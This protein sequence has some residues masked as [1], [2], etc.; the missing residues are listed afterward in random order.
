MLLTKKAQESR[1]VRYASEVLQ[2]ISVWL[3]LVCL[4]AQLAQLVSASLMTSCRPKV[5]AAVKNGYVSSHSQMIFLLFNCLPF[6]LGFLYFI[7]PA[8]Q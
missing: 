4:P 7:L 8:F 2:S 5:I 3:A 6:P 1:A